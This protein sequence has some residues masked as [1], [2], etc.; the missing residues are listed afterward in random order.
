MPSPKGC[1]ANQDTAL[2]FRLAWV[3]RA[4]PCRNLN[5]VGISDTPPPLQ[6]DESPE[7]GE[8]DQVQAE[9]D[10]AAEEASDLSAPRV[11]STT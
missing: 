5:A 7:E 2:T 4:H 3:P 8:G 9:A 11:S 6:D 1:K 10:A